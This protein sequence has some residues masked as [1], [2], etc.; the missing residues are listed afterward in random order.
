[1]PLAVPALASRAQPWPIRGEHERVIQH[2][3]CPV[4]EAH[5][6]PHHGHTDS[7]VGRDTLG[8]AYCCLLVGCCRHGRYVPRRSRRTVAARREEAPPPLAGDF[9]L[10]QELRYFR[11]CRRAGWEKQCF[12]PRQPGWRLITQESPASLALQK[13]RLDFCD[14]P[15]HTAQRGPKF[16]MIWPMG[17]IQLARPLDPQQ[18]GMRI[19][20]CRRRLTVA[21]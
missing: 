8:S 18:M 6:S 15:S 9:T 2:H 11:A 14:P 1:M 16:P 4:V 3:S 17:Q 12:P 21:M 5:W 19:W 7:A 10:L 20:R 13:P